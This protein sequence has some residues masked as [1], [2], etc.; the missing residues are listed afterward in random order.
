MLRQFLRNRRKAERIA[1]DEARDWL[2]NSEDGKRDYW[3]ALAEECAESS[4]IALLEDALKLPGD[5][6]E[7]GVFR[8]ASLRRIAK[9]LKDIAPERKVFGLDSFE[10]FPDG[11]VTAGVSLGRPFDGQIP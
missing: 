11:G 4:L 7:C 8:G 9:T 5:V 3:H 1:A 10:G 6:V 2:L